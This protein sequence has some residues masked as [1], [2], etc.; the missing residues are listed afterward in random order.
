MGLPPPGDQTFGIFVGG[1]G[2]YITYKNSGLHNSTLALI[3]LG[4]PPLGPEKNFSVWNISK[5]KFRLRR[6]FHE[7]GG[8]LPPN[9]LMDF[10]PAT[11]GKF[12]GYITKY[13]EYNGPQALTPP[14]PSPQVKKTLGSPWGCPRL[15]ISSRI[16][17]GNTE[18]S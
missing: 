4:P 3:L 18:T 15:K 14:P 13:T 1:G 7:G 12:F 8:G 10:W 16:A 11:G 9:I 6:N 5:K 17:Q 2:P